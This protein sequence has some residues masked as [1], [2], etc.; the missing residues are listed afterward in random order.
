MACSELSL[1]CTLGSVCAFMVATMVAYRAANMAT[2]GKVLI[3]FFCHFIWSLTACCGCCFFD[4]FLFDFDFNSRDQNSAVM[5]WHVVKRHWNVLCDLSVKRFLQLHVWKKVQSRETWSGLSCK[6]LRRIRY[7]G[8]RYIE[9][10][11]S[12]EI[13]GYWAIQKLSCSW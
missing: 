1:K 5:V 9:L 6:W 11:N 7:N 13:S 2:F 10:S 8:P 3:N 12:I 4:F